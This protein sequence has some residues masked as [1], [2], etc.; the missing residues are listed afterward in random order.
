MFRNNLAGLENLVKLA[1][2]T[3][4]QYLF[5]KNLF[6]FYIQ[7][8]QIL[9]KRF[10]QMILLGVLSKKYCAV[11]KNVIFMSFINIHFSNCKFLPFSSIDWFRF[12]KTLAIGPFRIPRYLD[13]WDKN[14]G[15]FLGFQSRLISAHVQQVNNLSESPQTEQVMEIGRYKCSQSCR[16]TVYC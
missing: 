1:W 3:K 8:G 4:S 12:Q 2:M 10:C 5:E 9:V 7:P 11:S 16:V 13:F 6:A 15:W 14:L